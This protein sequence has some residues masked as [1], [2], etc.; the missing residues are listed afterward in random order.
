[1]YPSD[2]EQR[3]FRSL[4]LERGDYLEVPMKMKE[5]APT[6]NRCW[7]RGSNYIGL[8]GDIKGDDAQFLNK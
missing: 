5:L 8:E 1:M 3:L 6:T 4:V 2:L 7:G